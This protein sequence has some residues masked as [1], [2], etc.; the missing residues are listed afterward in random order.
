MVEDTPVFYLD[1]GTTGLDV[2]R[3]HI[4]EIGVLCENSVCFSTVVRPPVFPDGPM[5]HG[6]TDDELKESPA[7]E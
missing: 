1:F 2:L 4:V 7:F 6:S 5:V 3:H